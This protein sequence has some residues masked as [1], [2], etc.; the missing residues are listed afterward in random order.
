LVERYHKNQ[1]LTWVSIAV[2]DIDDFKKINDT[3]WHWNWD[4][5]LRNLALVLESFFWK[6]E[7]SVFRKW[8]EE[9]VILSEID[10]SIFRKR[11]KKFFE[12]LK[13]KEIK[14]DSNNEIPISFSWATVHTKNL[15]FWDRQPEN[16]KLFNKKEI[17]EIIVSTLWQWL[18]E[19]K[20]LSWKGQIVEK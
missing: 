1:V 12:I 3:Y 18:I 11:L 15:E 17:Y 16:W 13:N 10:Y 9:F 5:I 20:S 7:F 4:N 6:D 19:A 2:L 8:W 14:R